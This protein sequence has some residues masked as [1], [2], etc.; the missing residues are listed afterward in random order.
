MHCPKCAQT[1][2]KVI[3]SRLLLEGQTIRRRRSC[4]DCGF[5]FTTY[6]SF[7]AELPVVVKSDG[8]RENYNREKILS[9]LKKACQKRPISIDQIEALLSNMESALSESGKKEVDA[10][11]I[12]EMIMERLKEVDPVS[13]VR[14]AS[15]YWEFKDI[16]DFVKSLQKNAPN[17]RQKKGEPTNDYGVLL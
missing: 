9:G 14:F 1:E 10:H 15:F 3:D 8:R 5:R 13:Y 16:S 12:G 6:E 17:P 4:T 11:E 2:T 7:E